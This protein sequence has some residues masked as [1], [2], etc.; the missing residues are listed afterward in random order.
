MKRSEIDKKIHQ[1]YLRWSPGDEMSTYEISKATGVKRQT[2][3]SIIRT[4][5]NKI[6]VNEGVPKSRS[7]H[8][9]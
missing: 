4:A 1:A 2:I 3:D 5:I 7:I 8:I 9:P 6:R